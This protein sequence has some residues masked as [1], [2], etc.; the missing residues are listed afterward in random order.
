L[1]VL[2]FWAGKTMPAEEVNSYRKRFSDEIAVLL[3][4]AIKTA[5]N[6]PSVATA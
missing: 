3:D 2:D 5:S 6:R 4:E 1:L